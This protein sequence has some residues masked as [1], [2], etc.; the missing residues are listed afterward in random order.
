MVNVLTAAAAKH[1]HVPIRN[2]LLSLND[3]LLMWQCS[4]TINAYDSKGNKRFASGSDDWEIAVDGI[5][6][7]ALEG[8]QGE[9]VYINEAPFSAEWSW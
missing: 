5:G 7:W 4:F 9:F 2:P 1:E 3:L 6:G 8:R